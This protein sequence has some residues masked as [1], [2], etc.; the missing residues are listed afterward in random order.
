MRE[1]SLTRGGKRSYIKGGT[2][3]NFDSGGPVP[4]HAGVGGLA[5]RAMDGRP[6]MWDWINAYTRYHFDVWLK[7]RINDPNS[8]MVFV[9]ARS[10]FIMRVAGKGA[11]GYVSTASG[12]HRNKW[13]STASAVSR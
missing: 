3:R 4:R 6:E 2:V 9:K 10:C 12:R 7:R 8:T 5:L 11:A 1:K 13:G